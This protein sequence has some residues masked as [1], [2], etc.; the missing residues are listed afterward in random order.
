MNIVLLDLDNHLRFAPL[1]LTRPIGNLRCGMWTNDERWKH[2][3]SDASVSYKTEDYLSDKYPLN[4]KDDNYWIDACVIPTPE[5]VVEIGKLMKDESLYVNGKFVAFRGKDF[6]QENP[7]KKEIDSFLYL[8]NRWSLYQLNE[9]VLKADFD[10]YIKD[11]TSFGLSPSNTLIG[12]KENLFIE[13]GARIECSVVNVASGPVYIGVNAEVMEGSL[14]R[15]GLALSEGATLKL[16]TKIYGPTSIG[17]Y[18]KV[19]GEVTNSV[20]QAYS[21]KGHDGFVGNS[22]IGEWCNL[23]ADTN[24]SNL[25][26]NYSKVRAYDYN[27]GNMEDTDVQFMGL[28][29]GDHCSSGINTMFN[30]ATVVGVSS[31]IFGQGF[32]PKYIPDFSWGGFKKDSVF[33]FEKALE[34]A[35]NMMS[36]RDR[37]LSDKDIKVL[38][39]LYS[40][41]Q[42]Y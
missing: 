2:Y 20:F 17:P 37:E 33:E 18:C 5:L 1:S 4:Q 31:T 16:G 35:K 40:E 27:T 36:R 24:T 42:N 38:K 32:P 7:Q 30:T 13:E 28:S 9:K 12:P 3:F 25:K 26:N 23:G 14:I 19:G 34:V 11:K 21:N 8:D 15:G 39:H 22:L 6:S 41:R 29:M 10:Y